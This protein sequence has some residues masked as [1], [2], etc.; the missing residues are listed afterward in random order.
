MKKINI[1]KNMNDLPFEIL[2]HIFRFVNFDIITHLFVSKNFY[3]IIISI[4]KF[5]SCRIQNMTQYTFLI[6]YNPQ[7]IELGF[8]KNI[9][10][11]KVNLKVLHYEKLFF[12]YVDFFDVTEF[13]E[14]DPEINIKCKKLSLRY[15]RNY[16][17]TCINS[18]H[19][20]TSLTCIILCGKIDWFTIDDGSMILER[21]SHLKNLQKINL[22]GWELKNRGLKSLS[23]H[24]IIKLKNVVIFGK[25]ELLRNYHELHII[26]TCHYETKLINGIL[27]GDYEKSI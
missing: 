7:I 8:L 22:I 20:L 12:K 27:K 5:K 15:C 21:L 14:L 11:K 23:N 17:N 6:K 2:E 3:N 18:F 16:F 10:I 19:Q 26:N 9:N 25:L 4:K 24:K 1:I 13:E